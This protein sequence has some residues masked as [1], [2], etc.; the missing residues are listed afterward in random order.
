VSNQRR[1]ALTIAAV[2]TL[3]GACGGGAP[4]VGTERAH[5]YPN[6]TCNPG[7]TCLSS[8]CVLVDVDGA[9]PPSDGGKSDGGQVTEAGDGAPTQEAGAPEVMS[10]AAPHPRLPQIANQGGPVLEHP[11]VQPFYYGGD[12]DTQDLDAFL[13]E[14]TKTTFWSQTTAEYGVGPLTVMPTITL[15]GPAPVSMTDDTL[16]DKLARNITGVFPPWGDADP[17]TIY[18]FVIPHGSTVTFSN[19]ATCCSDYGGYHFEVTTTAG[20][21]VPYAVICSCPAAFG[22]NLSPLDARTT[23]ISHELVEAA[24]DPFPGT[25]PAYSGVDHANG[26]WASLTGGETSDMCGMNPDANV[27]PPGATY[28]VQRSWSNA[29]ARASRNPCLPAPAGQPY[30]NAYPVLDQVDVG[31]ATQPYFTTGVKVPVGTTKTIDVILSSDGPADL[32]WDVGAYS[33]EDLWG[34]DTTNLGLLLDRSR[35]KN[36]DKLRLTISPKR[37]NP[38]FDA[39]VVVLI[40]RALAGAVPQ[41]NLSMS[42]ITLQ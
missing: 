20:L 12:P 34:G 31:T 5:C 1:G 15:P 14:L 10:L 13:K 2:L 9:P 19:G 36:G 17:N 21:T 8:F 24:T 3:A 16:A 25:N 26:V 39:Q 37:K 35:G 6:D 22:L 40:S 42:L 18:T 30:F 28:M 38:N 41:T 33:Y 7:L 23:T 11:R 29:A 32:M 4:A 27:V